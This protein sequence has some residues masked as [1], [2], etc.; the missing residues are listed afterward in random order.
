MPDGPPGAEGFATGWT[1]P[2]PFPTNRSYADVAAQL[3]PRLGPLLVGAF[4]VDELAVRS[5]A[6]G[7]GLGRRLLAA[8]C[9]GAAPDGRGW[10]ITSRSAPDAL[11]FY[12]R[13]G[14]HE[15]LPESGSATGDLVVLL[16]PQHPG[17]ASATL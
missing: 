12:R 6:R 5:S 10:L 4:E 11:T 1:T 9:D 17:A 14:W 7:S 16:A 15:V 8:L 3:G 2:D 13:C